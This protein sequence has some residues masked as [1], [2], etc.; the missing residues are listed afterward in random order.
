MTDA[1]LCCRCC[2]ASCLLLAIS[3]QLIVCLF[4]PPDIKYALIGG[5]IGLFLAAGFIIIKVC[6]IRKHI[7]DNTF[8]TSSTRGQHLPQRKRNQRSFLNESLELGYLYLC[9]KSNTYY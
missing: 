5:G 2:F 3:C 9:Q 1:L 8:H 7:R 4:F 6:I